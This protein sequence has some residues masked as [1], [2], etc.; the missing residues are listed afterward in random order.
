MTSAKQRTK[1]NA[2]DKSSPPPPDDVAKR[3]PKAAKGVSSPAGPGLLGRALTAAFY[4]ALVAAAAGLA[5]FYLQRVRDELSQTSRRQEAAAARTEELAK[6]VEAV[7]QQV[8]TM[9]LTVGSFESSLKDGQSELDKTNRAVRKGEA[10]TRRIEEVLHK[11]QNEILK[12][13]SDGIR[14]VKE[15]RERDF[16]SLEKTVEERLTELT[17]SINDNVVAFTEVQGETQSE[18][19]TLREKVQAVEGL[20]ALKHE[21]L[22]VSTAVADLRASSEGKVEVAE[23]LKAQVSSLEERLQTR[24]REAESTVQEMEEVKAAVQVTTSSLRESLSATEAFLQSLSGQVKTLEDGLQE[25]TATLRALEQN[26]QAKT[27]SAAQG[28]EDWELRLKT[29]EESAESLVASAA[30]QSE[31]LESVLSKYDSHESALATLSRDLQT[32]RPSGSGAEDTDVLSAVRKITEAQEA[33]SGD[34]GVLKNSLDKLQNAVSAQDRAQKELSSLDEGHKQQAV[35]H[36]QRL[37]TLEEAMKGQT[38]AD[39]VGDLQAS[40]SQAKNDLQRLRTAV[41]SLVAYSV[42]IETNEKDIGSLKTLM[43]ETKA[44][45][46]A[47]SIKLELVQEKV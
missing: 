22:A 44:S 37:A 8:D 35:E 39:S 20:S 27:A 15:A 11:L 10:E 40:V 19:Q 33:F 3:S 45:V 23:S 6:T 9:R 36:G 29:V 2:G 34:L 25:A 28:R 17:K 4:L 21:L 12:D 7:L 41:D 31:K 32:L 24:T 1:A 26:L 46:E 43:D 16:S 38:V 14:D 30:E 18:V 42:K 47:L 5:G 13:L